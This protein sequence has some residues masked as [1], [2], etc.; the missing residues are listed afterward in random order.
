MEFEEI[1]LWFSWISLFFWGGVLIW[2]TA[3]IVIRIRK[4]REWEN[5]Y[6]PTLDRDL[7]EWN[8]GSFYTLSELEQRRLDEIVRRQKAREKRASMR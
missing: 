3:T 8:V 4:E 1:L 7:A 5:T 2:C 6:V